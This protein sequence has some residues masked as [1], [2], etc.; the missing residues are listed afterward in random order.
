MNKDL[1]KVEQFLSYVL[2]HAAKPGDIQFQIDN[3]GYASIEELLQKSLLKPEVKKLGLTK[4]MILDVVA[5]SDKQRFS[6]NHEK[7]KI[8]ANQGHTLKHVNIVFNQW[9]P[10]VAV[11]HG[12]SLPNHELIKQSGLKKMQRQHVHLCL[13]K[14]TAINNGARFK[15][16]W[17]LYEVDAK[18]MHQDGYVFNIAENNMILVSDVP[19]QY[20]N[21]IEKNNDLKK[22]IKP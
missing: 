9:I 21:V 22:S 8:R 6:L 7:T 12:T 1:I 10:N 4:E 13:D 5:S 20:L 11:Y 18:K 3:D 14:N 17:V 19:F 2:R 15:K 16:G